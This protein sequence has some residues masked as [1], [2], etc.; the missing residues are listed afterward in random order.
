MSLQ[1]R[2]LKSCAGSTWYCCHIK[3]KN[4]KIADAGRKQV[5]ELW[6]FFLVG[7]FLTRRLCLCKR[8]FGSLAFL[9]YD[10]THCLG[11]RSSLKCRKVTYKMCVAHP[12]KWMPLFGSLLNGFWL[13]WM[14][15]IC[16]FASAWPSYESAK[17]VCVCSYNNF[18]L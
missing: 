8:G 17:L 10:V 9:D 11:M 12:W 5:F 4:K 7:A 18:A 3:N 15:R 16:D 14:A 13:L 2:N 6:Q 1:L